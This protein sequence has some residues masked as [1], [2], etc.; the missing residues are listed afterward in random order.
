MNVQIKVLKI[1]QIENP[2]F[3][4]GDHSGSNS[5]WKI[6]KNWKILTPTFGCGDHP[7]KIQN[8]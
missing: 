7:E 5:I 8:E 6:L 1:M 2:A 4:C 3:G